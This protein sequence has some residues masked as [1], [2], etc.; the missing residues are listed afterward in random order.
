MKIKNCITLL[1]F[2]LSFNSTHA[3]LRGAYLQDWV[4]GY[5]PACYKNQR[6]AALNSFMSDE[7]LSKYCTCSAFKTGLSSHLSN[8]LYEKINLKQ[9]KVPQE[10][11][12]G[13]LSYCN[14]NYN[15]YN[16]GALTSNRKPPTAFIYTDNSKHRFT[17]IQTITQDLQR[18]QLD[19]KSI[20][21]GEE[22]A[23]ITI[24]K[25]IG[26][27]TIEQNDGLKIS[28]EYTATISDFGKIIGIDFAFT[29]PD[30]IISFDI[31]KS[32]MIIQRLKNN[33]YELKTFILSKKLICDSLSTQVSQRNSQMVGG[34]LKEALI[35]AIR[36]Y[37]G[38]SYSYGTVS[39]LN[40]AGNPFTAGVTFYNNSWMGEHYSKGLD[41]LFNGATDISSINQQKE[42]I[43]CPN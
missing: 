6:G 21:I 37:A 35:F 40:S 20:K 5:I 1:L 16:S 13:V 32:T 31:E 2:I 41:E 18:N 27:L 23:D 19:N 4:T 42:S 43:G 36:S 12:N 28:S 29:I 14:E 3:Q 9:A 25:N 24:D 39:G 10:I 26:K 17:A 11:H 34:L 8:D 33:F 15:N 38:A 7:R 30:G 22:Y